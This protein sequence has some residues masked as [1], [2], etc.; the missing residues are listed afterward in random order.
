MLGASTSP[1]HTVATLE[2]LYWGKES[3]ANIYL[4]TIEDVVE[5]LLPGQ[6]PDIRVKGDIGGYT[7]QFT[8]AGKKIAQVELQV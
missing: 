3:I 1:G 4:H 6:R 8:M 2:H 7:Y 5:E